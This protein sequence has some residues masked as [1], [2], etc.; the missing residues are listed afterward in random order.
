MQCVEWEFKLEPLLQIVRYQSVSGDKMFPLHGPVFDLTSCGSK[1][2]CGETLCKSAFVE[3][4]CQKP[5]C[6]KIKVWLFLLGDRN[7]GEIFLRLLFACSQCT[8]VS[9]IIMTMASLC[10]VLAVYQAL[11]HLYVLCLHSPRRKVLIL[12]H[13]T[14]K[15]IE[16]PEVK[17]FASGQAV[18]RWQIPT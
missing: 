14:G 9:K 16:A 3:K 2:K 10:P 13:F 18:S 4:I 15:G 1:S 8:I 5:K 12:A 6:S 17:E 7:M 11:Q